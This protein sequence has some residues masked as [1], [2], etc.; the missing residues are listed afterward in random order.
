MSSKF[1]RFL[2]HWRNVYSGPLPRSAA[3]WPSPSEACKVAQQGGR[4]ARADFAPKI[5]GDAAYLNYQ[6]GASQADV[7]LALGFI[8]LGMGAL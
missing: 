8:R 3:N 2:G 1:R 5:V 6:Q 4:V 7:G